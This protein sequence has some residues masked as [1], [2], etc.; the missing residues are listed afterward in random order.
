MA[1]LTPEGLTIKTLDNV[2]TD[3]EAQAAIVFADM[4]KPGDVVDV[5]GN[6][7]L[8]RMIGVIAPS[9]FDVWEGIQQVHNS[10]SA[11]AATGI[12]LDNLVMLSAITRYPAT[13]TRA[14]V[15]LEGS[16]NTSVSDPAAVSNSITQRTYRLLSAGL[17]NAHQAS[18]P[19]LAA[20]SPKALEA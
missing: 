11:T 16:I 15:L 6:T 7:A 17:L 9:L 1:G 14:Q 13:P 10:F 5:S 12:A 2:I 20:D 3:L 8:G 19:G 18:G 4:V